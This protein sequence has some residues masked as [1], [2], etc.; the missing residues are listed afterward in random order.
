MFIG[1]SSEGLE[2]GKY[3]QI[4]L[5]NTRICTV[6]RWDQG[7]FQASSYTMESLERVAS[8]ADFAVLVATPDDTVQT[9][10]GHRAV[11][12]DNVIFELG[13]FIGALGRGRTYIV[14][15]QSRDLELPS[16]LR[17]LTWLPVDAPTDGNMQ[18]AVTRAAVGITERIRELG[19]LRAHPQSTGSSVVRDNEQQRLQAEIEL[20]CSGAR[21]QGWVVQTQSET[22]LRLR[23][24]KK[25]K[26]SLPLHDARSTR[27]A[28][29]P[30]A[31][32]LRANGLRLSLS[33]RRPLEH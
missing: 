20:I 1:S 13:L 30:F 32:R 5:Q 31:A 22:V 8:R 21:A 27:E 19:R 24:R 9:R 7:I 11:A 18:A 15:D 6:Q 29:R 12:R 28:L 16:D 23:D 10:G 4:E 3:L 26:F 17:G 14:A 2:I 33:V 25:R